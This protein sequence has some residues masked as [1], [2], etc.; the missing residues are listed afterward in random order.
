MD[1]AKLLQ[2]PINAS[3]HGHE[4]DF[5]I[6]LIHIF[7][8]IL[9]VGWGVFFIIALF[10]FRARKGH[11]ANYKGV[12]SHVS[13]YIE[14]AV[15]VF[16]AILLIGLS[17]PFWQKQI[18]TF[19]KRDDIVKVN[20]NAEQYA[21]NIHY[22]GPDGMFGKQSLEFFDKQANPMGLDP[23]D[24]FG[25]DDFTTIN[26]LYLPIGKPAVINLTSRDVIH[27][28]FIPVMRVKQDAIPGMSIPLW[29][30][31]TKTGKWEIACA[32]LCGIGHYNM[33]GYITVQ[34]EEAFQSWYD[35]QVPSEEEGAGFDDFWN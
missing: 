35:S 11:S 21:W 4:I 2:L 14:I 16:E 7:M 25:K 9:F 24:P 6:V 19:P 30:T 15:V 23:N 29:F 34:S 28:F 5:M 32:Q 26:Q 33:K 27:S 8:L 1:F 12:Q 20:I 31:P 17:I 22:P 3:S 13:S 10:K 18:N